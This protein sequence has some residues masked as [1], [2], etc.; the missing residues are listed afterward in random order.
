MRILIIEDNR[1]MAANLYDFFEA[2]GYVVD[3]CADGLT[4][5]H[6]AVNNSYDAIVLDVMLPGMDGFSLCR[7]LR[8]D[9]R[10]DTPVLMLTALDSVD[11][12]IFGLESGADDYLVK[13]FSLRELR[14][15]LLA[16]VRR[17]TGNTVDAVIRVGDLAYDTELMQVTRAQRKI[18]LPP[19]PLAILAELMKASPK[20]VKREDLAHAVWG[21]QPPDS[22]ALR[23]HLH[24]LRSAIDHVGE[25]PLLHTIRSVGYQICTPNEVHS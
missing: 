14:A 3:I 2:S 18:E 1:D 22:D 20:I 5:L 11:D 6:L 13:P 17:A 15:R 4:G 7:R 23:T 10:C 16:L 21:D 24:T 8:R 19:I 12:R 9:V 25:P